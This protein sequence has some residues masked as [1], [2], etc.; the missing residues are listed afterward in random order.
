MHSGI[1]GATEVLQQEVGQAGRI[2]LPAAVTLDRGRSPTVRHRRTARRRW[3]SRTTAGMF[4]GERLVI[5]T[6]RTRKR[7]IVSHRSRGTRID[8]RIAGVD[9]HGRQQ[10]TRPASPV[11]VLGAFA[12]G[13]VPPLTSPSAYAPGGPTTN[14][15]NGSTGDTSEAVRRHQRRRQH[16]LHRYTCDIP[17]SA[18]TDPATCTATSMAV[19][20]RRRP[21]RRRD[22]VADPA[23]QHHARTPTTVRASPT[24]CS[25]ADQRR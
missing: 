9:R 16:G 12:A 23:E 15:T 2:T 24:R 17:A 11:Q 1:R 8:G 4:V 3:T 18:A 13:V 14:F 7:W 21:S 6:A 19:E 25:A 10:C 20:R 22:G 5:D